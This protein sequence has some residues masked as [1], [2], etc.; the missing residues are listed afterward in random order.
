MAIVRDVSQNF[1][2]YIETNI[3]DKRFDYEPCRIVVVVEGEEGEEGR[4]QPSL[5]RREEKP[6]LRE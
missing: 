1:C 2:C 3:H 4:H 6:P 5:S